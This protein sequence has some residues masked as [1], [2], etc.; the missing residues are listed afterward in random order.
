MHE[1]S[2]GVTSRRW[3]VVYS[4]PRKEEFAEI[5]LRS[6]GL[7]TFFPRLLLPELAPGQRRVVPLFP[8]YL[9]VYIDC[10]SDEYAYVR[11]SPG[12]KRLVGFNGNPTPLDEGIV[13][14]LMGQA[15]A[16]GVIRAR[17][18]LKIG[19][20]VQIS[21]GPFDGL[22][23]IIEEPPNARG[24]VRVLMSLLNRQVKVEVP[25]RFVKNGWVSAANIDCSGWQLEH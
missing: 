8:S 11:W 14:F 21:G 5:S 16:T 3:Y 6:K 13:A 23:G 1:A 24:R 25:L 7:K 17:S 9:F 22:I 12:V 2:A 18:N 20:P 4:K 10:L 15:D 19:Q